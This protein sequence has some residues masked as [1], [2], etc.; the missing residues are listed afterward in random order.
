MEDTVI[1]SDQKGVSYQNLIGRKYVLIQ[2][3]NDDLP[4]ASGDVFQ[5]SPISRQWGL[6]QLTELLL[7]SLVSFKRLKTTHFK[8]WQPTDS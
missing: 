5:K 7:S 4:W 3:I 8:L 1:G 2:L 6:N